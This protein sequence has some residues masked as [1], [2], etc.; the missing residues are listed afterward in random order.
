MWLNRSQEYF[1]PVIRHHIFHQLIH[2]AFINI[3]DSFD[4]FFARFQAGD[5]FHGCHFLV[6]AA[7]VPAFRGGT[8]ESFGGGPCNQ[9]RPRAPV[10]DERLFRAIPKGAGAPRGRAPSE[11]V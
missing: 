7:P 11:P 6:Q 5:D 9:S 8:R 1:L 3:I 10:G 2:P 4:R